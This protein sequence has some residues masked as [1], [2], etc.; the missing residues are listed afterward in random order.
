MNGVS[1][2]R[3]AFTL[4][5]LLVVIAIIAILI[6][7]LLP[8]VQKVREAAARI[9]CENNL[10]QIALA[11]ANYE[12]A[13]QYFPPGLI[14]TPQSTDANG[15]A[16]NIP[17][18]YAGPYVGV[19]ALLLPYM[20]QNNIYNLI[21]SS[22]FQ[23]NT[24]AGA[25]AYNYPPFDFNDPTVPPN[26]VNGTGAG[27][28]A[29][30]ANTNIKSYLCP[31]DSLPDGGPGTNLFTQGVA[32]GVIDGMGIQIPPGT[33]TSTG[34]IYVDYILDVNNYGQQCGRTNYVGV[35]GAWGNVTSNWTDGADDGDTAPG[36]S[37]V[38]A[39]YTAFAGI[40]TMNSRTKISSI[41]D[42]T[43]NTLAFG[44]TLSGVHI[45]GQRSFEIAWMGAGW[46]YTGW[47][48]A[49]IYPN[50]FANPPNNDYVFRQFSSKHTGIINFAFADGSVHA[51]SRSA[52]FNTY[53]ALSGMADG[54]V[55]DLSQ[56]GL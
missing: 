15:G 4:I 14:V 40:Y 46:W 17:P 28:A 44:E 5:E 47:G 36:G 41:T 20:E 45:D 23:L 56:V 9:S 43:S 49:P 19:M 10:H 50:E 38:S 30:G 48:L 52:N 37:A 18:P 13:Y 32:Q 22:W 27:F 42:G 51:I 11:A 8:A 12:S 53:I 25:W 31:S 1:S 34:H 33:I 24:T 16:Y 6:G 35:G 39:T 26:L 2:R 21:P 29:Y 7:L 3:S 55:I 54:Q